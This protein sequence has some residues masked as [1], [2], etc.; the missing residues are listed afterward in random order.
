ML[1]GG[2]GIAEA[3]ALGPGALYGGEARLAL[4][5]E[6]GR[7]PRVGTLMEVPPSLL[8]HPCLVRPA[9]GVAGEQHFE[10]LGEAG[11]ARAV[12]PGHHGQAG[13]GRYLQ[14][15]LGPD[16]P[17]TRDGDVLQIDGG[18]LPAAFAGAVRNRRARL[19]GFTF[20]HPLRRLLPGESR[21]HQPDRPGVLA[22]ILQLLLNLLV[23]GH[24]RP[25][26]PVP[27]KHTNRV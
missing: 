4:H 17:E 27:H 16:A 5:L 2:V 9:Q 18:R 3:V 26:A 6:P 14:R 21:Q 22:L 19:D 1:G 13:A 11:L 23:E 15:H 20:E 25:P 8:P 10:R 7:N 24:S 12:A